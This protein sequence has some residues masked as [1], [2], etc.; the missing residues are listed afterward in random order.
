MGLNALEIEIPLS[1]P[2]RQQLR[3]IAK[4]ANTDEGGKGRQAE[5]GNHK[6]TINKAI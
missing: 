3:R 6:W 1:H 2:E 4:T 5:T